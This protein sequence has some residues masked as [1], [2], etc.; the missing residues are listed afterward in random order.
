EN[1]K[2]QVFFICH[3]FQMAVHYFKLAQITKRQSMSFGTFPVHLTDSGC[4]E[5]IFKGLTNPFW[6]ADFRYYQVVQPKLKRFEELGAEILALEKIR[7]HIPLERAIM[8][9]RFTPDMIG[10][11]F[12]PEADPD[13]M[14]V[15]FLDPERRKAVIAEHGLNKFHRMIE[16]LRNPKRISHTHERVLPNFVEEV[17]ARHAVSVTALT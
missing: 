11:Q 7:P 16:D 14:I 6:A 13:G 12:H 15:H 1:R 4:R 8:A 2:K 5:R 9:I 10:V 3:S 17:I